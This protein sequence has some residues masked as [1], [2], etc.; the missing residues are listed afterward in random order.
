MDK[1]YT[2]T[3]LQRAVAYLKSIGAIK[4]DN[5][6]ADKLKYSKGTVSAYIS[7]KTQP[8]PEF[9]KKFENYFKV[10]VSSF[11]KPLAKV[12]D[13][14]QNVVNEDQEDYFSPKYLLGIINTLS[15]AVNSQ[16]QTIH[17][18]ATKEVSEK[19]SSKAS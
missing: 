15:S 3:N 10:K 16:Q 9:I 13:S 11:N 5:E 18:Y 4:R 7:G 14:I 17:Y 19:K 1:N 12:Q 8:S 2:Q 6:I